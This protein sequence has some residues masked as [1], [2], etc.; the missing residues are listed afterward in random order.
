MPGGNS[1]YQAEQ[2]GLLPPDRLASCIVL[3]GS[4]SKK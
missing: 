4:A 2:Q 3:A 1:G